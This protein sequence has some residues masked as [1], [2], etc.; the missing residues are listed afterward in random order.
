MFHF[1]SVSNG[2]TSILSDIIITLQKSYE[3]IFAG[4]F[5]KLQILARDV[6]ETFQRRHGMDI[7]FEI[8]SRALKDITNDIFFEMF[9]RRLKDVTKSHLFWD[10]SKRS[11][12]CLSHWRS[13]W[14]LSETS[15]A[16]WDYESNSN[17]LEDVLYAFSSHPSVERIRRTV[18]TNEKF[19]VQQIP[20]DLVC[21]IT[22][23]LD[24]SKA[25]NVEDI[26][27]DMSKSAVDIH[28]PFIT[29]I[30]NFSF[31]NGCFRWSNIYWD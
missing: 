31:E 4:Y 3:T 17:T 21:K 7:I 16:G 19:S 2:L 25:T 27:V 26:P 10:V 5:E 12:R 15:Y 14:N 29:K 18:K 9:L 11:L 8:C 6:F 28:L 23:N 30:I 24:S 1:L 22:L 13:D 20:E